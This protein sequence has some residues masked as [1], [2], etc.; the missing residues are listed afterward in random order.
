MNTRNAILSFMAGASLLVTAS[1]QDAAGK[2]NFAGQVLFEQYQASQQ[3]RAQGL[4]PRK[5]VPETMLAIVEL[6]DGYDAAQIEGVEVMDRRGDMAIVS[7]CTADLMKVAG[8]KAVRRLSAGG[9]ARLA[10]DKARTAS[11][12]NRVMSARR[13][14]FR[15]TITDREWCSA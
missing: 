2:V 9:R 12:A 8:D 7:L 6:A 4:T 1:A 14:V 13:T 15:K 11:K 10:L 3:S 5:K